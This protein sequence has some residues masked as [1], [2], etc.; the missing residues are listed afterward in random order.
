MNGSDL[1]RPGLHG[2]NQK[3]PA[4]PILKKEK[5]ARSEKIYVEDMQEAHKGYKTPEKNKIRNQQ[6][7]NLVTINDVEPGGEAA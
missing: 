5:N 3:I 4:K 6:K 1:H 2:P 7:P